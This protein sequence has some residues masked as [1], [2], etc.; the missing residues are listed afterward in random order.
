MDA[1]TPAQTIELVARTGCKK[2]HMRIDKLFWNSFMAGP[3]LGFGCA[4][5]LSVNASPWYEENAPG[6]LR[7]LGALLF[8][9]GLVMIVMSGA[10]LWTTNIMACSSSLERFL[11]RWSE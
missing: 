2:A 4:I 3:L 5:L 7:M 9:V 1:F 11:E 6:L 10:D 8:P